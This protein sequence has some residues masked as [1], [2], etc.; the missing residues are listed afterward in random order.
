MWYIIETSPPT[1]QAVRMLIRITRMLSTNLE[2]SFTIKAAMRMRLST[3]PKKL[4][5]RST[6]STAAIPII[7]VTL[8]SE[9][10][11]EML[12][13]MLSILDSNCRSC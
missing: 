10:V 13:E 9:A 12:A 3:M 2:L 4:T 6:P 1:T 5:R 8:Q 7:A 11:T